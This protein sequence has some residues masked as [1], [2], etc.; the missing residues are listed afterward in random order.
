[1]K[2][3]YKESGNFWLFYIPKLIPVYLYQKN[4][5]MGVK[6]GILAISGIFVLPL[7]LLV[8]VQARNFCAAKTT[9]ER[10]SKRK[11][12]GENRNTI[13]EST[14]SD[15]MSGNLLN[16]EDDPE[17]PKKQLV[18]NEP[19]QNFVVNCWEM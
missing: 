16:G 7:L 8:L 2:V 4:V 11:P 6:I 13:V 17:A 15:S 9:N 10:Y 19:K 5:I 1:M 14:S 18:L 3:N 12:A